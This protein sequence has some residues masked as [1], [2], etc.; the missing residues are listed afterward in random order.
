MPDFFCSAF[1]TII[2][3]D[4]FTDGRFLLKI[5]GSEKS[6]NL[7][8]LI[9]YTTNRFDF[10]LSY[11]TNKRTDKIQFYNELRFIKT[12]SNQLKTKIIFIQNNPWESKYVDIKLGSPTHNFLNFT[13]IRSFGYSTLPTVDGI[14]AKDKELPCF[15]DHPYFN[16]LMLDAGI[17]VKLLDEMYG[18]PTVLSQYKDSFIALAFITLTY[19]VSTMKI[20]E[21]LYHGVVTYVPTPK[22]LRILASLPGMEFSFIH[23]TYEIG[24]E[25]FQYIEYYNSELSKFFYFFDSFEELKKLM[26][27]ADVDPRNVREEGQK[28]WANQRIKSTKQWKIV[29]EI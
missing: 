3:G 15:H 11:S 16:E 10:G 14:S 17:K 1:T 8:K 13:L 28:F 25:W 21:N 20:Y 7:K 24:N 12:I 26:D 5:L 6:C 2:V 19:Q 22:F 4:V 18:G 9:F 23:D 27:N 29:L